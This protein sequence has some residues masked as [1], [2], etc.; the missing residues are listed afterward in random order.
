MALRMADPLAVISAE[1]AAETAESAAESHWVLLAIRMLAAHSCARTGKASEGQ[2]SGGFSVKFSG[3]ASETEQGRR[4]LTRNLFERKIYIALPRASRFPIPNIFIAGPGLNS[5]QPT[6]ERSSAH[7]GDLS[8]ERVEMA[9]RI[10]IEC[11]TSHMQQFS[12]TAPD[13]S[14]VK[15]L[16]GK[17]M[18]AMTVNAG[19]DFA[20]HMGMEPQLFQPFFLVIL[21]GE[22]LEVRVATY[23]F[24]AVKHQQV[25]GDR[26]ES[27]RTPFCVRLLSPDLM[28]AGDTDAAQSWQASYSMR[29]VNISS[30]MEAVVAD[31]P[32]VRQA[33]TSSSWGPLRRQ[34]MMAF[35]W[36]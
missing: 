1:S 36:N 34:F 33:I 8:D 22:P 32:H 21:M 17:A 3:K 12:G 27:K 6:V 10:F 20:E 2:V 29:K 26:P 7:K 15:A 24:V 19:I 5:V 14:V 4:D 16:C 35:A 13:P 25:T 31:M 18:L 9:G 23:G 28:R 30:I 11:I